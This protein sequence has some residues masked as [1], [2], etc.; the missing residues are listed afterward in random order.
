[1]SNFEITVASVPHRDELVAE[2]SC[3]RVAWAEISHETD[4]MLIEFYPHPHKEC[5]E[6][7]LEDVIQ[8]LEKAKKRMIALGPKHPTP[9]GARCVDIES[10]GDHFRSGIIY[11]ISN[12][13]GL[14]SFTM[15]SAA[16]DPKVPSNRI[17]LS[18]KNTLRGKLVLKDIESVS[19][20][21]ENDILPKDQTFQNTCIQECIIEPKSLK[22]KFQTESKVIHMKICA[23]RIYWKNFPT[24]DLEALKEN[25]C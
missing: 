15:E 22:L 17:I 20:D 16:I 6:I 18:D 19:I 11:S 4:E 25:L 3:D 5:W 24:L 2:I 8:A 9:L 10:Y 12:Q 23:K 1:M 13:E 21:G 7:P 14:A